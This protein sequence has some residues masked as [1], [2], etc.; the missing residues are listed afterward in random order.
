MFRYRVKEPPPKYLFPEWK[1]KEGFVVLRAEGRD[2]TAEIEYEGDPELMRRVEEAVLQCS[3]V[4]GHG[5]ERFTTPLDLEIAMR[6]SG[7]K[8]FAPERIEGVFHDE[9]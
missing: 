5:I 3:G 6:S 2:D 7:M 4:R 1:Q 8:R 9:A